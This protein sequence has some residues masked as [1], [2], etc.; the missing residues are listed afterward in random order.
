MP[1]PQTIESYTRPELHKIVDLYNLGFDLKKLQKNKEELIKQLKKVPKKKLI[2]L[3]SK[4]ELKN[5]T[6]RKKVPKAKEGQ[7]NIKDFFN[8]ENI[9]KEPDMKKLK[10]L[11][12]S[13]VGG[14]NS[15]HIKNMV[16]L[17]KEGSTFKKAH[18]KVKEAEPQSYKDEMD[19]NLKE[20]AE[21]RKKIKAK[22]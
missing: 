3:P 17:M 8:A 21:I 10:E 16:K 7:K 14:M 15:E 20:V 18:E 4:A 19:A 11:S 13:Y 1:S 12:K 9:I 5:H 22:K 2:D 6:L